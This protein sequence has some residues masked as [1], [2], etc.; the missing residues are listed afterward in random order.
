MTDASLL[1]LSVAGFFGGLLLVSRT[2]SWL[3]GLFVLLHE[4]GSTASTRPWPAALFLHSGP[5]LLAL[6]VAGCV[7]VASLPWPAFGALC[8]GFGLAVSIVVAS[9]AH[10]KW[11][12]RHPAR[13]PRPLTPERLA[14]LRREFYLLMT[15]T[16]TIVGICLAA[17]QCWATLDRDYPRV[18]QAGLTGLLAGPFSC[19]MMW[20]W[21]G[22]SLEVQEKRRLRALERRD[23]ARS[24]A[25]PST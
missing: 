7:R 18:I 1:A 19:W 25:S 16:M 20:Q 24:T 9:V 3:L 17:W 2:S 23:R 4:S 13:E 6:A 5:W 15:G 8:G 14:G 10:S 22:N 11:R 21:I 12:A